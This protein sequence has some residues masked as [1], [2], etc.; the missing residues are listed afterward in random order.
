MTNLK[1]VFRYA[2]L[3]IASIISVFPFLWMIVS[4]TNKSVDV[5]KG[6]LL[7]GN[8]FMQNLHNLL[9]TADLGT[10]L[11]NSAKIS[12]TTTVLAMLIASLA[13]YGC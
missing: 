7:P 10:A 5:T 12:I 9:D 8:H 4:S 11:M 13:G 1:R 3:V 6:R 2:V